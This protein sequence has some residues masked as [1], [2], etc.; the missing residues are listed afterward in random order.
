MWYVWRSYKDIFVGHDSVLI[1]KEE[2][3]MTMNK[4]NINSK[5]DIVHQEVQDYKN[6]NIELSDEALASVSGGMTFKCWKCG[7]TEIRDKQG[8]LL[9]DTCGTYG[10]HIRTFL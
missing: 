2:C 3:I 10:N 7:S 4:N 9:C 5:E 8:E 6:S 1:K